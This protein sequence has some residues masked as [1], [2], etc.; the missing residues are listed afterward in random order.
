MKVLIVDA[1]GGVPSS[2]LEACK[3]E[4]WQAQVVAEPPKRRKAQVR[5]A[6]RA[7]GVDAIILMAQAGKL[8]PALPATL[9]F[10]RGQGAPLL[11][12]TDLDRSGWDRTFN[13]PEALEVDALFDLPIEPEAVVR[14]LKRILDARAHT[15]SGSLP[16]GGGA[17]VDRA[18]ANE[19]A[20]AAFYSRAAKS[21]LRSDTKESLEALARDEKEHKRLLLEFRK[22]RRPLPSTPAE[23]SGV[24]EQMGAADVT[25]DMGPA[26]A[27]LLAARKE[28]LSID[29]YESWAS[30]YP[31]GPERDLL[32]Q[33]AEV[34]RRHKA[35]VEAMFTN[36]AFPE[37]W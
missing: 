34:E 37:R 23:T 9:D 20:A 6:H 8:S 10:A 24:L 12:A 11:L 25:A 27:F 16:P 36:A 30:L 35:S 21:V 32:K 15:R 29:F 28:K 7:G 3:A 13:S 19:E 22:G 26:D 17:I 4:H 1:S 5:T 18:I 14:R 33:L 2:L 31:A